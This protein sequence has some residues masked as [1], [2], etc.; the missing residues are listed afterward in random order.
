MNWN[1]HFA[2]N[3]HNT[4]LGPR[5]WLSGHIFYTDDLTHLII[6]SLFCWAETLRKQEI[7]E[8]FFFIRYAENGPHLRLRLLGQ[9]DKLLAEA[10]PFLEEKT[11]IY[12]I[13]RPSKKV[14][15]RLSEWYPNDSLVWIA[16]EPEID[17]Y[18]GPIAIRLAEKHFQ[19]SSETIGRGIASAE[20]TYS[21]SVGLAIQLHAVYSFFMLDTIAERI[22]FWNTFTANWSMYMLKTQNLKNTSNYNMLLDTYNKY[23]AIFDKQKLA[24]TPF[25]SNLWI[26]LNTQSD[27]QESWYMDWIEHMRQH[28]R[29]IDV[30]V[31]SG[32]MKTPYTTNPLS[33]AGRQ[34]LLHSYIHMSNNRLGISNYDE[35][36]IGYIMQKL[37]ST[38]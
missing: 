35:G 19:A 33:I 18:G 26:M 10:V 15:T 12:F 17:R 20:L 9:P 1:E 16:Y 30:L 8:G 28:R 21:H 2:A 34:Y 31:Q 14:I 3:L 32:Q 7:I 22:D 11:K 37:L 24:L 36:Y 6:D 25:F 38:C 23:E 5:T 4:T 27:F 29:D 13:Q